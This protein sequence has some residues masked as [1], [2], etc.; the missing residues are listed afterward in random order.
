MISIYMNSSSEH[1]PQPDSI[2][3]DLGCS[4]NCKISIHLLYNLYDGNLFRTKCMYE[5][6]ELECG[7]D[8][9]VIKSTDDEFIKKKNAVDG[10]C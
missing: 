1:R 2:Y 9:W 6:L 10:I 3:M 4:A 8:K 5:F 7:Y